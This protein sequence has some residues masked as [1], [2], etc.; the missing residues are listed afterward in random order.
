MKKVIVIIISL[1]LLSGVGI[2]IYLLTDKKNE[3]IVEDLSLTIYTVE[4][5]SKTFLSEVVNETV[6]DNRLVNTEKLGK[7]E[8]EYS[9]N[10]DEKK[11]IIIDV[12]DTTPPV[13]ML[14]DIYYH[15]K[16]TDFT[17]LEDTVCADN[18]DDK[19]KC[20]VKCD[21]DISKEGEYDAIYT[22]EDS[23]G[24]VL[25]KEFKVKVVVPTKEEKKV[26]SFEDFKKR[27]GNN[28]LLIDVSKWEK[29]IDWKKVKESGIEYAF[30]RLGTEKYNTN[31][32]IL[33][34]YF[35]KNYREAKEN[36][37]KVGVYFYTYAKSIEE[38]EIRANFVLDN[39]KDKEIDL[40]V[41]YDFECW[42]IYNSLNLSIHK[43]NVI[44]DRFM[45]KMK[46]KGYRPILYSSKNYLEK[47]WDVNTDVWL[48]HYTEETNYQG[49]K[50]IW[51]FSPNGE[52]PGITTKLVDINVY[53]E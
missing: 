53:Y 47:I 21:L 30:I 34:P 25:K 18:Y 1:L 11:K 23:S 44:K 5:Y 10:D 36:G 19:P 45:E 14:N 4:V 22:A 41:A 13:V 51:Q 8:L 15:V 24:N 9:N 3:D 33:D 37:I 6:K 49:D 32:M 20:S 52:I 29:D 12:V 16:D 38:V 28:K 31:E 2:T 50:I 48:A 46:E 27:A 40:G 43:L 35:E 7:Y 17:I 26:I 42:E 39:I